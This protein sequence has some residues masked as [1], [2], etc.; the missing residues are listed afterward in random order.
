MD[1]S[2]YA[3]EPLAPPRR[4]TCSRQRL[5][6]LA[7]IVTI[8]GRMNA[9]KENIRKVAKTSS[10]VMLTGETGTGKELAAQSVHTSS[11]RKGRFIS[12]NCAAIPATLME[13][14]LFGTRKGS[15]SC[16]L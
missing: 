13:S 11:G 16:L 4:L 10:A 8:D 12:Q 5:Y 7:D 3:A 9:L 6:T 2:S 15:L 14:I 1:V